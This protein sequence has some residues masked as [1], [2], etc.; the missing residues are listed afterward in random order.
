MFDDFRTRLAKFI[1][2]Q[3]SHTAG[4]R[5]E[6]VS[7]LDTNSL[8]KKY[9]VNPKTAISIPAV[10]ACIKVIAETIATLPCHV[11]ERTDDKIIRTKNHNLNYLLHHSPNGYIT[12]VNFFETILVHTLIYGNAFVEIERD[13][14]LEVEALH[15]LSPDNMNVV[16]ENGTVG[17]EYSNDGIIKKYSKDEIIHIAGLSGNGLMG[18]SPIYT[19]HTDL[20]VMLA[21][22]N[23]SLDFF[24]NGAK[25]TPILTSD[26]KLSAEVRTN[27]KNS[28]RTSFEKGIVLLENGIKVEPITMALSDAQFLES[29]TFSL[30]D[31]CRIYRVPPHMAGDLSHATFSNIE[32][33]YIAFVRDTIVTWCVRLENAFGM[34]LFN[35]TDKTEYFIK[36]VV[37][38]LLR[39]DTATRQAAY[40]T[41]LE[42]GVITVNEWREKENLPPIDEPWANDHFIN[43]QI[44][45]IETAY[46][47]NITTTTSS[48]TTTIQNQKELDNNAKKTDANNSDDDTTTK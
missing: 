24:S 43:Q 25:K 47:T 21:Q 30:Q 8:A 5:G 31:C 48:N 11:Y 19:F 9:N 18:F 13:K 12:K 32:H 45:P 33:E 40:K 27:L 6:F 14:M 23:F 2:P 20:S 4:S 17:Y 42:N 26:T 7:L 44:R 22:S 16:F 37:D 41:Q 3:N 38:G 28:F 29:K 35:R 34:K 46:L 1:L 36:F 15:L 39:G 10:W